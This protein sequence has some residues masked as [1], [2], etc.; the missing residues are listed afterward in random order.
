M[1]GLLPWASLLHNWAR[2]AQQQDASEFLAF[3]L[4]KLCSDAFA[5]TWAARLNDGDVIERRDQG[6][7][8][9]PLPLAV[10]DQTQSVSLQQLLND[11]HA[12]EAT[13]ALSKAP[14]FLFLQLKR[15]K[16]VGS[17]VCKL[18]T[19]V[20][21]SPAARLSVPCFTSEAS[22]DTLPATYKLCFAVRVPMSMQ[23]TTVVPWL[24]MVTPRPFCLV[25]TVL[26][27]N[28]LKIHNAP[29]LRPTVT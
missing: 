23:V 8:P 29:G 14:Q 25:T 15:Y 28:P 20:V 13:F 24:S 10:P 9:P 27:R 11:W 12:Q 7:I 16:Q 4:H 2:L 5:G 17:E 3:L 6:A 26:R 22:L 1:P 19:P 21:L 18:C